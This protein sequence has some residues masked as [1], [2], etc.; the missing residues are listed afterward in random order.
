[1]A[2]R[3]AVPPAS[4]LIVAAFERFVANEGHCPE[5]TRGA[6]SMKRTAIILQ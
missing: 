5:K 3:A 4:F 2:R 6:A 1:V